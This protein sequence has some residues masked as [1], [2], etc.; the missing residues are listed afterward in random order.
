MRKLISIVGASGVGKTTFVNTLAKTGRFATAFEQHAE[1]PFQSL[2]K[3]DKQ[4]ALANQMDYLLLRAEQEKQLRAS[5]KIGLMDG[6]LDLDFHGF[7]RLFR[8]RGLLTHPE[9]DLCLRLYT[10]L[11]ELL[12]PPDLI[13]VLSASQIT[14][15]GR[16]AS[17]RRI[18]IASAQDA[19]LMDGFIREWLESISPE[20]ILRIDASNEDENYS[21]A[22]SRLFERIESG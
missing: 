15:E 20:K 1:R 11:R 10:L 14:I 3:Q 16:L 22:A 4:Y 5:D 17:R 8:H 13:V 19:E 21:G 2:F 18:N 7:T 12:P 6:G 9:F